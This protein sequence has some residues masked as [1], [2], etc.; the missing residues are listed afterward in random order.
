MLENFKTPLH[1]QTVSANNRNCLPGPERKAQIKQ[2][3]NVTET[4]R[5]EQWKSVTVHAM[6]SLSICLTVQPAVCVCVCAN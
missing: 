3:T 1:S 5:E 4:L 2:A 6:I